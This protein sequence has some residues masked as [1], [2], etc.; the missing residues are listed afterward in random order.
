MQQKSAH[1][2]YF[3]G[4]MILAIVARIF[5]FPFA[6]TIDA[7]AVSRTFLSMDWLEHPKWIGEGVWLPIHYYLNGFAL[8]IWNDQVFSPAVLNTLL[9]IASIPPIYHLSK[10]EFSINGALFVAAIFA[11]SP[12]LFRNQFMALSETSYL[13]FVVHALNLLSK[14][15][16][17]ERI[18][19]FALS[20]LLLTVAAGIR[21]EAWLI[22]AVIGLFLVFRSFKNAFIYGSF[23]LLFPI[24]WLVS[25]YLLSGNAFTSLSGNHRWTLEIMDNNANVDLETSLRRIWFFPFSLLIAIGPPAAYFALK[26]S[27]REIRANGW[28]FKK[29]LGILFI[30]M[31][32]FFIYNS[33]Q[34]TLLLQ[35]RFIGSLV[36]LTLP[37]AALG[38]Q[39][40]SFQRV[41]LHLFVVIGLSFVYNMDNISPLPRL[42]D[43]E[44][45]KLY[46]EIPSNS[47]YLVIDVLGWDYAYYYAL[48]SR[49]DRKK[50]ILVEGAMN[51]PDRSA[52]IQA[53]LNSGANVTLMIRKESPIDSLLKERKDLL[54]ISEYD[55]VC[56]KKNSPSKGAI[57]K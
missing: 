22:M 13:F 7:D 34:G 18:V 3:L 10:R 8:M 29:L 17:D 54:F 49:M 20:G 26:G 32:L 46:Q 27:F 50:I 36:I 15:M 37:F 42:N 52:E 16:K 14:G 5:V 1:Q 31:L 11:F 30:L 51:S 48:M 24:S 33:F 47:D 55:D 9:S 41:V 4:I 23:A 53:V 40:L 21:Y 6:Q 12:I 56:I 44:K 28:N 45:A 43:Q 39:Q 38:F 57:S 19:L 2:S 35:H 25:N